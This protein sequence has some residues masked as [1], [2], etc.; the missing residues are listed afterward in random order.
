MN[1]SIKYKLSRAKKLNYLL[2]L[3]AFWGISLSTNAQTLR[4][5][6]QKGQIFYHDINL[7]AKLALQ[8]KDVDMNVEIPLFATLRYEVVAHNADTTIFKTE[9]TALKF[10]FNVKGK[11]FYFDSQKDSAENGKFASLTELLN[12]PFEIHYDKYRKVTN[13]NIDDL[14]K[15]LY[16]KKS[17][18]SALEEDTQNFIE[19]EDT[20]HTDLEE[21]GNA[22][23][24]MFEEEQFCE[25]ITLFIFPEKAIKK[26]MK[27]K[28]NTTTDGVN[29]ITTYKVAQTS[30]AQTT[31]SSI[32]KTNIDLSKLGLGK[33]VKNLDLRIKKPTSSSQIVFD[34][35][36]GWLHSI[37]SVSTVSVEADSGAYKATVNITIMYDVAVRAGN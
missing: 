4:L 30:N 2:I 20:T 3:F 9:L 37:N 16:E 13:I 26:G 34:N 7:S 36:T 29:T 27:W 25:A 17:K 21:N 1:R 8:A 11:S 15:M 23:S 33:K 10:D 18:Q 35:L 31:I 28:Q 22:V 5:N 12:K 6:V 14:K 32:T 19:N 24:S